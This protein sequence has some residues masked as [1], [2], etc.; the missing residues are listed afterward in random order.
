MSNLVFPDAV[1]GTDPDP[2]KQIEEVAERMHEQL[3]KYGLGL[4]AMLQHT[5]FIRKD[6]IPPLE[7]L[8]RFHPATYQVA[9][10]LRT[11]KSV[12]TI[13][14]MPEFPDPKT[15]AMLEIVA[16][17]PLSEEHGQDGYTRVPFEYGPPEIAET[18]GDH[19][20]VFTAGTEGLDFQ[21]GQLAPDLDGQ[22]EKIV[23]KLLRAASAAGLTLSQMIQHNLYVTVGNDPLKVI[24]KFHRELER[25]EPSVTDH[26]SSGSL[27]VVNGMAVDAFHLEVDAVLTK[28]GPDVPDRVPLGHLQ[29]AE[30]VANGNLV[31]VSAMPGV[32]FEHNMVLADNL[33]KQIG[34]AVRNVANALTRQG[35][36]L[37]KMVKYRLILKKGVGD[38]ARVQARFLEELTNLAPTLKACPAAQSLLIVESLIGDHQVEIAAV[39]ER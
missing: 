2:L 13:I 19:M 27:M 9:P 3:G 17:K 34:L 39:A 37:E 6:V 15:A 23:D 31:F 7:A 26:L 5:L 24:E 4:E 1:Y 10:R 29:V 28:L 8:A 20:Q 30:S 11:H 25:R 18:V 16:G 32:D 36:S 38:V 12:G 21:S 35:S 22:I 33:E 14:Q